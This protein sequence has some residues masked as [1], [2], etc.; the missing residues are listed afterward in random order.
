VGMIH[1][2]SDIQDEIGVVAVSTQIKD[3]YY[4][5]CKIRLHQSTGWYNFKSIL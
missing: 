3:K 4:C 1:F 5:F 2:I